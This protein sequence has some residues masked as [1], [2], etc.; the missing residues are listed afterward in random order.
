M[1]QP[2]FFH[3]ISHLLNR[4]GALLTGLAL[5]LLTACAT[6]QNTS[7]NERVGTYNIEDAKA[8]LGQPSQVEDLE[9]GSVRAHWVAQQQY[10]T[11][12]H[13]AYSGSSHDPRT[14]DPTGQGLHS[15]IFGTAESNESSLILTFNEEGILTA[16]DTSGF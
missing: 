4:S 9:D 14:D 12:Y 3:S 13:N 5:V 15:D 10:R 6:F 8:E 7:W 16:W 1:K 2:Q 11:R